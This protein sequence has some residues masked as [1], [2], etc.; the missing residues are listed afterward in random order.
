MV[1]ATKY[2]QKD[3]RICSNTYIYP[4]VLCQVD[5]EHSTHVPCLY[6]EGE[7]PFLSMRGGYVPSSES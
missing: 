4:L 2:F 6:V 5:S 7:R 1:N 3:V